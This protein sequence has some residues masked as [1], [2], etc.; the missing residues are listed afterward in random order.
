MGAQYSDIEEEEEEEDTIYNKDTQEEKESP[1]VNS[2]H[3]SCKSD[4]Y[5]K[6]E[7]MTGIILYRY[8]GEKSWTINNITY[9]AGY[10][11]LCKNNHLK[12]QQNESMYLQCCK[13]LFG[14]H[15]DYSKII[16]TGIQFDKTKK[17]WTTTATTIITLLNQPKN[18]QS[19]ENY[20]KIWL[21]I[22]LKEWINSGYTKQT[23]MTQPAVWSWYRLGKW[24]HYD[25]NT[26]KYIE[27]EYRN[28]YS[29]NIENK[30]N[31]ISIKLTDPK[32]NSVI[33]KDP[34]KKKTYGKY[35]IYF[36]TQISL[37][38]TSI[39]SRQ[40]PKWKNDTDITNSYYLQKNCVTNKYRIVRRK[41]MK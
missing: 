2:F 28:I 26:I 9:K 11:Y 17:E 24:R 40:N 35:E 16:A 27:K 1:L 25:I 7:D 18:N 19:D 8:N 4:Q 33:F 30:S 22:L 6:N 13:K 3:I 34:K 39:H 36:E 38:P 15:C 20:E 21:D 23:I 37:H 29:K 32:N 31:E 12:Y 41:E 14:N 10:I 5:T